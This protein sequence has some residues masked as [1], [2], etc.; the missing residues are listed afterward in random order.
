ML[1]SPSMTKC[2]R[3]GDRRGV[4]KSQLAFRSRCVRCQRVDTSK[5]VDTWESTSY[6]VSICLPSLQG[7]EGSRKEWGWRG[8]RWWRSLYHLN[9]GWGSGGM[10]DLNTPSAK[11]TWYYACGMQKPWWELTNSILLVTTARWLVLK[12]ALSTHLL[13]FLIWRNQG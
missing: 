12:S 6:L 11:L 1:L 3:L 5:G 13:C 2:R 9:V 4:C 10:R 8:G 7:R